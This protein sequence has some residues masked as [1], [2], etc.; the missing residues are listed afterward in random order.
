M[1]ESFFDKRD[2]LR[3]ERIIE[4]IIT[5]I[6]MNEGRLIRF[7]YFEETAKSGKYF[8][9]MRIWLT[10]KDNDEPLMWWDPEEYKGSKE[11]YVYDSAYYFRGK[12]LF[13]YLRRRLGQ[14]LAGFQ[15]SYRI[16]KLLIWLLKRNRIRAL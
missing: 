10:G 8:P 16:K 11:K 9:K 1:N 4:A 13:N 6:K 3:L 5:N 7:E 2:L 14:L 12:N 15:L